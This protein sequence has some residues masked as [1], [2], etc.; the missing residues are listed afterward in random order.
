VKVLP[1]ERERKSSVTQQ[2]GINK[3]L[4]NIVKTQVSRWVGLVTAL[5]RS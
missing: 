5:V 1:G 2:L 4:L 3:G